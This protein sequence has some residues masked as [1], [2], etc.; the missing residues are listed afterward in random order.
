MRL[1]ART[2]AVLG[3]VGLGLGNV[4]RIPGIALGG[5]S[6]PLVVAD[7]V[8]AL[9]WGVLIFAVASGRARILVDDVMSATLAF[10]AVATISTGL[11]FARFNLG[12]IE[13]AGVAAFLIRWIAYF[14]WYPFVAWCLTGDESRD[15]WRFIE[16]ALLVF[17]VA[18]IIQS[19]FLPGF[20]QMIHDGG[21]LP[22]WDVQGR[23]LVSSMLDPNFAGIL[24]VIALLVR[25]ARVAEGLSESPVSL[26]VLSAAL[27]LTVSRSAILALAVGLVVVAGARGFRTR[28]FK[29]IAVGVVLILPFLSLLISFAGSFGKLGYD[30]SAA[31]RLIPWIRAGRLL[32][33]HPWFGVGFNA[34]KQAQESHG[35]RSVGGADVSF[36]GGLI[37]VAAMTGFVGLFFYL[38]ML[39]R[40]WRGAR[41]VWRDNALAPADRAHATATAAVTAAVVVHSFFVNSLLLPFVMQ[42]MWVMW[43][44]LAHIRAA[45]RARLGLAV[46]IPLALVAGCDPCAGAVSCSTSPRVTLTGTVVNHD[47]GTP[48]AGA[49][50]DIHV[51]SANA[52]TTDGSA[53]TD[54]QGLWQASAPAS[55]EG[56]AMARVTVTAPQLLPYT[57]SNLPVRASRQSGDAT[58]VG[59]W[60]D[61][62]FA[63]YLTTI[64]HAGTPLAN[65]DVSF[66]VTSGPELVAAQTSATTNGIGIFE[67]D[68]VGQDLGRVIGDLTVTHPSLTRPFVVHGVAIPLDHHF[69]VAAPTGTI[70]VG[71][72]LAYGGELI[73]RGTNAKAPGVGVEFQRTGGIATTEN[74]FT[75]VTSS[76]GFFVVNLVPAA[77]DADGEVIGDLTFRPPGSTPTTYKN[78]RLATYDS[79]FLRSMGLWAYGE[80]WAWALELWRNDSL[81]PAPG[82]RVQF[83]RT[84]GL[85]IAP[86]T[87]DGLVTASNGRI[88]LRAS[89]LDTGVVDGQLTVTPQTGP[90]RVITGIHL[91]TNADDQLHFGG[92]VSFGPALRY[93]VEVLTPDGAPV[94]GARVQWTQ[95]SG[96]AATPAVV[97]TVTDASGR[98]PLTLFPSMDGGVIG[99][100]RVRPPAPWP[101]GAEYVFE[102]LRLDTF[103][104]SELKLAATYRIPRP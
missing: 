77:D 11:A 94:V 69:A 47:T 78:I 90:P 33:E 19:A 103:E 61:I 6:S 44:R 73:F 91:R 12:V 3:A 57:V 104:S 13:G 79:T 53:T 45:R 43:G 100:V 74:R 21:D 35:W 62:P 31:Q 32:R 93:T 88:E 36:D 58:V 66:R 38:R 34:I 76:A 30:A 17:A 102:P 50:I 96:I 22:T 95:T 9:V 28:L 101:A 68:F 56:S 46:A 81:K 37:F 4:G 49:R 84:G 83:T 97:D 23:R 80:R 54:A 26:A 85:A 42:I 60:S 89:V 55:D 82:V 25:L 75:T 67:L 20:A 86:S 39:V 41:R 70:R 51:T 5:R 14:G 71:K 98:I 52:A 29:V 63:K 24:I 92:V 2:V 64:V 10:L 7:L 15:A 65:A 59:L 40:V 1:S 48:I 16:R 99:R 87:L 27:L 18:G 8:V 72:L